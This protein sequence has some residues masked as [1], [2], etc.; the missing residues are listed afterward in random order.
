[1]LDRKHNSLA[2]TLWVAGTPDLK[3]MMWSIY[4]KLKG[5]PVFDVDSYR[6]PNCGWLSHYASTRANPKD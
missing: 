2:T 4:S 3:G 6:C 1:M 5:Q